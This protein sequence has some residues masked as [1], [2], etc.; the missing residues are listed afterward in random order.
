MPA[1]I[2]RLKN[3]YFAVPIQ[4]VR[5][6]LMMPEI[7]RVPKVP[8]YIRGVI[9]LRGQVMPLVDLRRRLGMVSAVD[10]ADGFCNL[11]TQ[12]EQDHRK[13][14]AELEACVRECREFRLTTD[15]HKC[16]FGKWYDTYQSDNVWIAALLKRF[17]KP[18][19]KIHEVG[20][21]V[22][23]LVAGGS[24]D[25]ALDLLAE[26]RGRELSSMIQLFESL[27]DLVR[28]EQRETAVIFTISGHVFAGS[29]DSAVSVEKLTP[30]SVARLPEGAGASRANPVQRTGRRAKDNELILILEADRVLN[31]ELVAKL[32]A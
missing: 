12:R 14:L 16:A 32:A 4:N 23:Q 19:K 28:E 10:E 31:R 3:Q 26:T 7:A 9:N 5:E 2:V 15:P 24:S 13:W 29:V 30:G 21:Q 1:V 22:I 25:R 17:D 20:Q 6:M 18:H 11:M 27:R 8:D